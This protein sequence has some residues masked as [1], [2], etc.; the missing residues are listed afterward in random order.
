MNLEGYIYT[1][2][3]YIKGYD[4]MELKTNRPNVILGSQE[5]TCPVT[6]KCC[7]IY[8]KF[9]EIRKIGHAFGDLDYIYCKDE[10]ILQMSNQSTQRIERILENLNE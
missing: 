7:K 8:C 9:L 6:K 3:A 4:V 10:R 1:P 5:Y 2:W